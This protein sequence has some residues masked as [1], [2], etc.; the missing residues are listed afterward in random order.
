MTDKSLSWAII[1]IEAAMANAVRQRAYYRRLLND[2]EKPG[3]AGYLALIRGMHHKW[4][5][6]ALGLEAAR[7][8]VEQVK[9]GHE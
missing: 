4:D 3:D 2:P 9:E 7:R 8:I 6:K 5:G 1:Q